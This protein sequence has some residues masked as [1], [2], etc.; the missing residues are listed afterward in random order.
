MKR[1]SFILLACLLNGFLFA[2][3][4]T[5]RHGEFP[6]S[7]ATHKVVLDGQSKIVSW[8]S[9]Q[10][11]AYDRFLRDRWNFIFKG[12]PDCPGPAPRSDYPHYYFYCAYKDQKMIPDT[13]M[14]DVG[15]KIPNWFESAR[16]YYQYTGDRRALDIIAGMIN[17]TID[18][19]TSPAGFAWPGFPYTT[20][21]AGDTLF[22]GFTNSGVNSLVLHEVQVDHAGDMGFA[23]YKLYLYTG[24]E[25]FKTAAV[26]V[27]DA[28]AAHARTGSA[29][30]S[31]WP[32]RVVMK[33]G[34]ITAQY[35][36][37]WLGCYALLDH[38]VKANLGN[39]KAY[40]PAL[41]KA[42]DFI[43]Q[44]PMKTGYW[45]DG[46]TDTD[47]NSNTYKSNMSASNATLYMFDNPGFDPDYKT[48]IPKLIQ[49]TEKNFVLRCATGEPSTQWGA[50]IVGEQDGFL[51][52][53]DYQTARYGGECARWYRLSGDT[54][55]KEKAYRALNWVT[56]CSD[57][58]GLAFESP[59]SKGV[60][61]WWSDCY[62]EGPRMFYHAL[63][64]MPEWA[65][66]GENHILYSADVLTDVSYE[67]NKVDYRATGGPGQEFLR[68]AFKP[69]MIRV[70]GSAIS[71]ED[72]LLKEGYTLRPLGNS[73]YALI[74]KRSASGPVSVE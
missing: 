57:S 72:D 18:H 52:K 32:Y 37:N 2:Q 65:P 63:A 34:R 43:L 13:W 33:D 14:N 40:R 66:P 47:V 45:T 21:N 49:W 68:L 22:R 3:K 62:G 51:P 64:A 25:K 67:K 73:D 10:S 56:Y 12:I 15:E 55:Y 26:R 50:N 29:T 16:L 36:A 1:N 41:A 48:D 35:G 20:T 39:V 27:A 23:Y 44:F 53:M 5:D 19:G 61:S 4:S 30:Q 7:I 59:L 74:I 31:V 28:L 54:T 11:L 70:N 6:D 38:L 8:I 42:R 60:T 71:P 46:H 69:S 17:Y 24:N 58:N 9:P